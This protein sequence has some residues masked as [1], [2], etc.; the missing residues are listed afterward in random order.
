MSLL[1]YHYFKKKKHAALA[2]LPRLLRPESRPSGEGGCKLGAA[3]T[4]SAFVGANILIKE[5]WINK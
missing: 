3:A 5:K 4:T 2:S 1:H